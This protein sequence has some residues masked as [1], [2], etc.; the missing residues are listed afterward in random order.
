M[1]HSAGRTHLIEGIGNE[2]LVGLGGLLGGLVGM[3][4]FVNQRRRQGIHPDNFANVASTR[5]MLQHESEGGR[6]SQ[7]PR[8]SQRNSGELTCPICLGTAVFAVETNCGHIYCG[9]CIITYWQHQSILGP[10]RC[11]SCRTQVSLLL[12]NFTSQEHAAESEERQDV[13]DKINQ[14]NRRFSGAPRTIQEYFQD[15]PTLLRHA[16]H[17]FFSLG[18][19]MWMFR[20][21]I[22]ILVL[23]AFLY[24]ISPLDILPEGA[25]G[26]VGFLDDIFI[27]FLVAIYISIIY[28]QVVASRGT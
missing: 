19:L 28:R 4:I 2:V 18:G 14:Y 12:L 3:L 25:L 23:A 13:I 16:F 10:V 20:F 15:L 6:N 27:I 22:G 17:E 9:R 8:A 1:S 24:L 7:S 21:R 5:E 11:P 26:I